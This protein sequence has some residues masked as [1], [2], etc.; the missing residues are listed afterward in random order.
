ML[1]VVVNG[2]PSIGQQIMVGGGYIGTQ[3]VSAVQGLPAS[4]T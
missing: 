2:V 4:K 3:T 1:H